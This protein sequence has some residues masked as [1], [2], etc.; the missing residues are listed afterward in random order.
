MSINSKDLISLIQLAIKE[1]FGELGDITSLATIES[2]RKAKFVI[3]NREDITLCGNDIIDISLKYFDSELNLV[4]NFNDGDFIKANSIIAQGE[5]GARAILAIERIMLNLLQ[6]LCG[7]ASATRNYVDLVKHTKA[8]IRDTRK[9]LPLYRDMQ[10]YAVKIG[11]G[12]NHRFT[13]DEMIL[14]KDNHIAIAGGVVQA[15]RV[16]KAKYP[17]KIIEIECDTLEQVKEALQTN[18]EEILLD[19]MSVEALKEAVKLNNGR[20]KLEASGGVNINNVKS[21]AETGVD[22]IAIGSLTHSVKASDIGL[23]I[24]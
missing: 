6:H 18:C 3:S 24:D 13:L 5:G 14:I 10:K 12:E 16:A 7:I 11:G 4:K 23:D 22:Y 2:Q 1:D 8:I 17:N 19:N 20:M 15:F 21:I 9:T